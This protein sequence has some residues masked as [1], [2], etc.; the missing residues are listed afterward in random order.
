[1]VLPFPL[2]GAPMSTA[3][4]LLLPAICTYFPPA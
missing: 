1:M 4:A 3:A 2:R